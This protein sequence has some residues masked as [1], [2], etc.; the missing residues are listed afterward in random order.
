[1]P[2]ITGASRLAAIMTL[3]LRPF[4]KN[5]EIAKTKL[6]EFQQQAQAIGSGTLRTIALGFGLVGF[7][8]IDVAKDFNEIESQLRAIGGRDNIDKVIDQARE[9]GR[10]TKF[11]STEVV[12][13]GLELRK[14]GF[15]ADRVTGA[16]TVAT[17]LSQLFGGDLSKVGVTIAEVQ[18]QFKGANGE[19]RSFEDIGDIFAV[20]FKES[21]LDITNLGGALKNVGTVASQSGLT[22]EKTV[23][24]LGG[25]ANS[26]QKAERAGTRLK[27]TLIRLGRE[28]GFTEDQTQIL[29]SGTLDIGQ[30][31]DLLKNRAGL[32]GAVISQNSKEIAILEER[33]LDA[34]G[35]LDA[36]SQGLEGEL[37]ISVAKVKAGL[38]DMAITLGDALAPYVE[39][40]SELVSDF[41]KYFDGL[42][43]STKDSIAQ[44]TILSVLLP[45]LTAA[46]AGL[47]AASLALWANPGIGAIALLSA[48]FLDL[49]IKA[50]AYR[51][52]QE[53][54]NK[55]FDQFYDLMVGV[56]ENGD[57]IFDP[58]LLAESSTQA[59]E[60][61]L[62]NTETAIDAARKRVQRAEEQRQRA[63]NRAIASGQAAAAASP[64]LADDTAATKKARKELI[65]LYGQQGDLLDILEKREDR[66]LELADERLEVA[67]RYSESLGLNNE[68]TLK[69]QETWYKTGS[70]IAEALGKFGFAVDDLEVVREK[71]EQ[72]NDLSFLDVLADGFPTDLL[73]GILD[74]GSLE[75]QK[76]LVEAIVKELEKIGLEAVGQD[77]V[78][79]AKL[80]E[81]ASRSYEA[82]LKKLAAR[83]ELKGITDA[84]REAI[85]LAESM[86]ELG[87][88]TEEAYLKSK[89][90]AYTSE[91]EGLLGMGYSET[92][93]TVVDLTK[94]IEDLNKKIGELSAKN[95]LEKALGAPADVELYAQGIGIFTKSLAGLASLETARL[96]SDLDAIYA[97]FNDP[98]GT[99]TVEDLEKAIR[100]WLQALDAQEFLEEKEKIDDA[101]KDLVPK[102]K[103]LNESIRLGDLNQEDAANERIALLREE[104][105]LLEQRKILTGE[106]SKR[107]KAARVELQQN[108][109]IAKD[110]ENAAGITAFFQ[111]QISFLGDAFLAAAQNG[112]DFFTVLK[113]SFLD[114]F[115]ALVAKL[116]TLI[117]LYGILAV[118][119]GGASAGAGGIKGAAAAAMGENFG[120]FLGTN[121]T[122]VNRS[123]AVGSSSASTPGSDDGSLKVMGAVSGNNLVIMNQRGKRAFDRT[124]G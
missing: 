94:K 103:S 33:L 93:K 104:I 19:L 68:L 85:G 17:K 38:E 37:F 12:T 2:S 76:K 18:R 59:L 99:K 23:A 56:N 124:F 29:Q 71:I 81:E 114:T 26:G 109:A 87:L 66:L 79:F 80:W 45:V 30:I 65:S 107:L 120:S 115:Y 88:S 55:A 112:E 101:L 67:R 46:F 118:V 25:L 40:L 116:I 108:L 122:G 20:A 113:K 61:V 3:D 97:N 47:I 14:L 7:A 36:M 106:E 121:L 100:K 98:N 8:A 69:F 31:F 86:K 32:A 110:F 15:D 21:A 77:A 96:K 89:L 5:T 75:D 11:T 13:L 35:A 48:V 70:T 43:L 58:R 72:I 91:L 62:K 74:K 64:L 82:T 90:T 44:L 119:S 105:D 28:F 57:T 22:L 117:A 16:M 49:Q 92:G 52:E 9:L 27:T 111:S 42:S 63:I 39:S 54:L 41:A 6:Y 83:I 60:Q 50:A 84:R 24:L 4:L 10:T 102:F 78:D 123:L 73:D 51:K 1:M 95:A 53:Q 34:K